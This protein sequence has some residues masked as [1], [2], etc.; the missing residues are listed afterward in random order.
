MLTSSSFFHNFLFYS[1]SS[2][3][4]IFFMIFLFIYFF[5]I[6]NLI[7]HS[8]LNFRS[9]IIALSFFLFLHILDNIFLLVLTIIRY[10]F[11]LLLFFFYIFFFPFFIIFIFI[12]I[13]LFSGFVVNK[14]ANI[15]PIR[16]NRFYFCRLDEV[17]AN[18]GVFCLFTLK[19]N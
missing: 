7:K 4:F 15:E 8:I 3:L 10:S 9:K 6:S 18:P 17:L 12:F 16:E 13:F 19:N 2:C 11:I 5:L 14:E 1:W